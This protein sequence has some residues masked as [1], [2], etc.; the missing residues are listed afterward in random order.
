VRLPL[1]GSIV[2]R[3]GTVTGID[4][5][6]FRATLKEELLQAWRALKAA[7]PDERFYSF[8]VDIGA[9]AEYLLVTAS[10]EEGLARVAD[11]YAEKSGGDPARQRVALRWWTGDSPLQDTEQVFLSRS[12][13]LREAG[14]DPYEDSSEADAWIALVYD[15]AVQ[16]LAGLDREGAFGSDLERE[17]LVLSIWGDQPDEERLAFARALN[18]PAVAARFAHELKEG[19]LAFKAMPRARA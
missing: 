17:R 3:T 10:T 1:N 16:G 11:R 9:C 13:A 15:A 18:P 19:N 6:L 5:P 4:S 12:R 8:G 14:P 7:H 2:S